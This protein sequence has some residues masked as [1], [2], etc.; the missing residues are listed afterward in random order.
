MKRKVFISL[1]CVIVLGFVYR[2][3]FETTHT[4]TDHNDVNAI[5]MEGLTEPGETAGLPLEGSILDIQ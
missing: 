2:A 4:E 1:F 3:G 5:L